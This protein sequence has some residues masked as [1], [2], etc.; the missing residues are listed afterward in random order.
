VA[1]KNSSREF[2]I[3]KKKKKKWIDSRF[4]DEM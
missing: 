1:A 3:F 2:K 4:F